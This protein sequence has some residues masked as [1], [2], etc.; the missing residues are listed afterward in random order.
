MNADLPTV[1]VTAAHREREREIF[2]DTLGGRSRLVYLSDLPEGERRAAIDEATVLA[3]YETA[4]MMLD[5]AFRPSKLK[6]IQFLVAGVDHIRFSDVPDGILVAAN[7]G[8]RASEMA[9]HAVALALACA[10][11]LLVE[12]E[13]LKH[14]EFNQFTSHPGQLAGGKAAILGYGGAGRATARLLEA[15]GMAIHAINRSGRTE[16]DL[17]F[18]GTLDDLDTVLCDADL[19]VVT[20]ALT[21]KTERIVGAK[22]L[23]LMK[24][25]GILVNVARGEIVDEDALYAH[26]AARPKF[27]AGIDA[28]WVEPVRHGAFRMAHPFLEL[29]NVVG[30]P[31]NSS[32]SPSGMIHAAKRAA[33]NIAAFLDGATPHSLVEADEK[34]R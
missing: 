22:Q 20:L 3:G 30:S 7:R 29:P 23:S 32:Q 24:E 8:H 34:L 9:E 15:F 17:A 13:K 25:T 2:E 11:R 6:F 19:A 28:W 27:F 18:I 31:H 10:R 26:L 21:A 4:H 1:V 33:G 16:D 5:G 14:G 12:H